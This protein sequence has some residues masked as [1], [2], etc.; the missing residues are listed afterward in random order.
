MDL[1]IKGRHERTFEGVRCC[2]SVDIYHDFT[3]YEPLEVKAEES[4]APVHVVGVKCDTCEAEKQEA[5][6]PASEVVK[7]ILQDLGVPLGTEKPSH[8][9]TCSVTGICSRCSREIREEQEASRGTEQVQS[10]VHD[11]GAM[12]PG[13]EPNDVCRRC[14]AKG[15]KL[16]EFTNPNTGLC[17]SCDVEVKAALEQARKIT[18]INRPEPAPPLPS[19]VL[20]DE[21]PLPESLVQPKAPYETFRWCG[22]LRYKCNKLWPQSKTPCGFDTHDELV[23]L[24]H[25]RS[26]HKTPKPAAASLMPTLFDAEGQEIRKVD[27]TSHEDE[28]PQFKYVFADEKKR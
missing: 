3:C 13:V 7:D 5:P 10:F 24:E 26:V 12:R 2:V 14:G 17:K 22:Q 21:Q 9:A 8:S 4:K 20:R 16:D 15:W 19:E 28:E 1:T 25:I 18:H 11:P 27:V 23:M 6:K